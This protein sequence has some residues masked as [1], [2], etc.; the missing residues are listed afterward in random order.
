M[1]MENAAAQAYRNITAKDVQ[2]ALSVIVQTLEERDSAAV[3]IMLVQMIDRVE[4]DPAT[5]E[6]V[7][8][9]RVAASDKTGDQMV[10]PRGF[11]PLLPT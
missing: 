3:K 1:D 2:R 4:L 9:Y 10:L 8:T 7:I 6:A 5:F 11:E